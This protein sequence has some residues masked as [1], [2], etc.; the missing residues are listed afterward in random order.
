MKKLYQSE[1]WK[2]YSRRRQKSQAKKRAR[3]RRRQALRHRT[4]IGPGRRPKQKPQEVVSAPKNFSL[5]QN[6]VEVLDFIERMKNAFLKRH[7]VELDLK[8][9]TNMTSDAIAL[10]VACV[11]HKHFRNGCSIGGNIPN[12]KDVALVLKESGFYKHFQTTVTV[13]EPVKGRIC[14][15]KGKKVELDTIDEVRDFA[16]V[17]LFGRKRKNGGL[18]RAFIECMA[19][20]RDHA[21]EHPEE[22]E[23]WWT[24]VFVDETAQ[25]AGFSFIDMGVGIFRSRKMRSLAVSIKRLLGLQKNCDVLKEIA[26]GRLGS[27]TKLKYRG[28]GL[29]SIYRAFERGHIRNLV[30]L[31][32][33][34]FADFARNRFLSLNHPFDGTFLYWEIDK[35]Q[36]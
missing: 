17:A 25:K 14:K 26:D 10:L 4:F 34:A 1:Q 36:K 31:S 35:A 7:D 22:P 9:V 16:H 21:A 32:N 30:I 18:Q 27:R 5:T 28:K 19:N 12:D 20:T 33:D 6:P 23:L 15:R 8:R 24:T 2:R 13:D 11:K 3:W 29:P